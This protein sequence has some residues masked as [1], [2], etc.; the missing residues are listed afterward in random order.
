M[1]S[2]RAA[3]L[4][5]ESRG[6]PASLKLHL[7]HAGYRS[8]AENVV[9]AIAL[10]VERSLRCARE[11][12]G[13]HGTALTEIEY[14]TRSLAGAAIP[15]IHVIGQRRRCTDC[16]DQQTHYNSEKDSHRLVPPSTDRLLT[17]LARELDQ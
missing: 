17:L 9:A 8:G 4:Q 2:P 13:D 12:T 15:A 16:Q 5:R 11:G 6:T 1:R 14:D 10:T 7:P 3:Q